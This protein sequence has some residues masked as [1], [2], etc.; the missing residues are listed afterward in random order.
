VAKRVAEWTV[1]SYVGNRANVRQGPPRDWGGK[2]PID[3]YLEDVM[4]HG[5]ADTVVPYAISV[6][7]SSNLT[8]AAVYNELHPLAGYDHYPVMAN[9][10]Y[11]T[12]LVGAI[13]DYMITFAKLTTG[14]PQPAAPVRLG[15][16]FLQFANG[17]FTFDITGPTN[18]TVAVQQ[19]TN[20]M[21]TWQSIATNQLLTGTAWVTNAASA[22]SQFYRVRIISP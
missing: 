19:S 1:A 4:I 9:N 2:D 12:N 10:V 15:S 5:T 7:L 17:Q 6:N 14:N 18:L 8:A 16:Q 20:Q 11:N 13:I 22:T 21:N 3:F